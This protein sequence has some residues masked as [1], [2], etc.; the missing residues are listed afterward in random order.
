MDTTSYHYSDDAKDTDLEEDYLVV[1]VYVICKIMSARI[2]QE[3]GNYCLECWQER[4][5]PSL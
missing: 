3:E 5:H 1:H 2:F 4:T